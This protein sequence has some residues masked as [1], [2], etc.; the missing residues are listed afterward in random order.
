MMIF[1]KLNKTHVNIGNGDGTYF[2]CPMLHIKKIGV[3]DAIKAKIH[4]D[5]DSKTRNEC[6]EQLLALC[7]EVFPIEKQESLVRFDILDALD[8]A[9]YL[10]YGTGDSEPDEDQKKMIYPSQKKTKK[11]QKAK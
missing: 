6:K 10:M 9:E 8:L 1:E 3:L 7:N 4:E 11:V 5:T 2:E